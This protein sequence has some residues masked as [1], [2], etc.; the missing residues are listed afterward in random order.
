MQRLGDEEEPLMGAG[1]IGRRAIQAVAR[2]APWACDSRIRRLGYSEA[3]LITRVVHWWRD[4]E[5]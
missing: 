3:G 5:I 4:H 1:E 2:M